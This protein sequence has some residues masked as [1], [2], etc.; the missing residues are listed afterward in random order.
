MGKRPV[1]TRGKKPPAPSVRKRPA[2]PDLKAQIAAEIYAALE[3][4]DA[5]EDLLA[6]KTGK[7]ED[8]PISGIFG[9]CR[10]SFFKGLGQTLRM[11]KLAGTPVVLPS[12]NCN[13]S[14]LPRYPA[15]ARR[16]LYSA[17]SGDNPCS[18]SSNGR[19]P[20]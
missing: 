15:V 20:R 14:V 3:R 11:K 18:T 6:I 12:R 7:F 13:K 16:D 17:I 9:D 8:S 2:A 1:R 19:S 4:L 5:D 10:K